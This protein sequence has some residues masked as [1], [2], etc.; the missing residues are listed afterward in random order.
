MKTNYASVVL[1]L[2][3]INNT[4]DVELNSIR[5]FDICSILD[6]IVCTLVYE[7]YYLCMA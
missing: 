1:M 3:V 2:P 7:Q 5:G 6:V 4:Q